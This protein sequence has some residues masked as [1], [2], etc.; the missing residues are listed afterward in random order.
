MDPRCASQEHLSE[1]CTVGTTASRLPRASANQQ[2]TPKPKARMKNVTLTIFALTTVICRADLFDNEAQLALRYG[3]PVQMA[4]DSRF[5]RWGGIYVAVQL[6]DIGQGYKVSVSEAYK[7]EDAGRLTPS[8]I[9]KCLPSPTTG[10]K[11]I[12]RS[13]TEWQLRKK[14]IVARL[15]EEGT[16]IVM[17]RAKSQ[18]SHESLSGSSRVPRRPGATEAAP[19]DRGSGHPGARPGYGLLRPHQLGETSLAVLFNYRAANRVA[20]YAQQT[21]AHGNLLCEISTF[22]TLGPRSGLSFSGSPTF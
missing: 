2:V 6:K 12:Q 1:F 15:V 9:A 19:T 20:E 22:A 17:G 13:D 11:W 18:R 8:D 7:R 10:G 5:Y 21:A 4:G 14:P 16:V 3:R